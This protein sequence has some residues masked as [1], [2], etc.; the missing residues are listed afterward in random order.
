MR[1]I[2][3]LFIVAIVTPSIAA[4]S[5]PFARRISLGLTHPTNPT[6]SGS[7]GTITVSVSVV[8]SPDVPANSVSVEVDFKEV[9]NSGNVSYWITPQSGTKEVLL[10]GAGVST[11]ADFTLTTASNNLTADQDIV[12][13]FSIRSVS[14]AGDGET[15]PSLEDPRTLDMTVKVGKTS[16]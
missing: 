9:S 15:K 8:S 11:Q 4:P 1:L 7:S 16:D 12:L 10:K 13:Q 5:T 3:G 2:L 6:V 14:I